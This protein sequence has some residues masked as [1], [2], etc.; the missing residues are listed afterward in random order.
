MIMRKIILIT[1]F[2]LVAA[3]IAEVGAYDAKAGTLK[4]NFKKGWNLIPLWGGDSNFPNTCGDNYLG[5]AIFIWSPTEKKYI[6]GKWEQVS[7][8]SEVTR[9][10]NRDRD[11]MYY[12][13]QNEFGA[14]FVLRDSDCEATAR[15]YSSIKEDELPKFKIPAGWNFIAIHPW[16]VGRSFGEF[17]GTCDVTKAYTFD[18]VTGW[19]GG[20]V[21]KSDMDNAFVSEQYAGVTYA[22]KFASD[23][24][25]ALKITT[26][27]PPPLPE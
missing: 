21:S 1:V 12:Y 17:L 15:I 20:S 18:P 11:N 23:C 4:F 5:K 22:M 14:A 2:L 3:S 7:G 19:Q 26:L 8:D 24:N 27:V 6:G 16:M 13:A 10:F 9:I 25:F